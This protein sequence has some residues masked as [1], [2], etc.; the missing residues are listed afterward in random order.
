MK[1]RFLIPL[2]IFVVLLAFLGVGLTL[3]PREVPS[4]LIGKP[5]PAFELPRLDQADLE[6]LLAY[7]ENGRARA[8]FVTL[9]ANRI[10][11]ATAK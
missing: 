6:A 10:T 11:R 4:P 2:A 3:N 1:A 7:E 8:P 5:A 9:L